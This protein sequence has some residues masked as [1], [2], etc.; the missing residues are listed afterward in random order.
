MT[1]NTV[2]SYSAYDP[3]GWAGALMDARVFSAFSVPHSCILSSLTA[4]NQNELRAISAISPDFLRQQ[5]QVLL[6]EGLPAVMKIGALGNLD[7]L[8]ILCAFLEEYKIPCVLDP[9]LS[10]SS[11]SALLPNE[12]FHYF[13][14]QL[15]PRSSLI[16]PNVQ[17][18]ELL[19][20]I[21]IK[22]RGS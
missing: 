13:R 19:S 21:S 9:V 12:A 4:Q 3:S 14:K 10:T 22:G 17:E 5:I 15:I 2:W 18:A 8:R 1:V 11:G 16:T 6:K 20:G 7:A